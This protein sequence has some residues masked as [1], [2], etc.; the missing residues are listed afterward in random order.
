[1]LQWL[2]HEANDGHLNSTYLVTL[3]RNVK[4]QKI[5][6]LNSLNHI[7]IKVELYRAQI[8]LTNCYNCQNFGLV[9]ANCKQPPLCLWCCGGHLNRECPEKTYR[10]YVKLLQLHPGRRRET[11]SSIILRLQPC[12]R[13]TAQEKSRTSSQGIFWENVFL[14]S[15]SH[16]SSPMRLRCVKTFNTTN[17]RHCRHMGKACGS[18]CSSICHNRKFREQVSQ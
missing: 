8:G 2:Q 10:I 5:F 4:S 18:P 11:S 9:W 1:M 12:E 15:P 3:T 17:C 13:R 16:Q 7:M 6:K 14:L